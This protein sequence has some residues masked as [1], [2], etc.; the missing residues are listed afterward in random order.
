MFR[1][2]QSPTSAIT[3]LIREIDRYVQDEFKEEKDESDKMSTMTPIQLLEE[4]K[5]ILLTTRNC[6]PVPR[7]ELEMLCL[8]VDVTG[9]KVHPSIKQRGCVLLTSREPILR[10]QLLKEGLKIKGTVLEEYGGRLKI[11]FENEE[12]VKRNLNEENS[13]LEAYIDMTTMDRCSNFK[14]KLSDLYL[15]NSLFKTIVDFAYEKNYS[16]PRS[17]FPDIDKI[18]RSSEFLTSVKDLNEFQQEAVRLSASCKEFHI[19]HGPPGTGKTR[20]LVHLLQL[21]LKQRMKVLVCSHSNMAVDK[22]IIEAEKLGLFKELQ[23]SPLRYGDPAR[24]DEPSVKYNIRKLMSDWFKRGL[25]RDHSTKDQLTKKIFGNAQLV[26]STQ[27]SMMRE[28]F[29]NFYSQESQ[30]FDFVLFDEASQSPFVTSLMP[31]QVTR[32]IILAGDHQQLPPVI[33]IID[34]SA[35]QNYPPDQ[36]YQQSLFQRLVTKQ[37][38]ASSISSR[39]DYCYSTMLRLQFRMNE[40]IALTSNDFFYQGKLLSDKKNQRLC[41]ANYSPARNG[42][43][44]F[45]DQSVPIVWIDCQSQETKIIDRKGFNNKEEANLVVA[46]VDDLMKNLNIQP[47]NIGII[48]SYKEQQQLVTNTLREHYKDLYNSAIR[49]KLE[50]STVDGFQGREKEI[51][52]FSATR[53]NNGDKVGFL[54]DER[55]INV[56]ITRA[57]RLVVMIGNSRTLCTQFKQTFTTNYFKNVEKYGDVLTFNSLSRRLVL[58]NRDKKQKYEYIEHSYSV[59]DNILNP[60][61]YFT[62]DPELAQSR[63]KGVFIPDYIEK[64]F[65]E[66]D[67]DINSDTQGNEQNFNPEKGYWGNLMNNE[68]PSFKKEPKETGIS[69]FDEENTILGNNANQQTS[70]FMNSNNEKDKS[71]NMFSKSFNYEEWRIDRNKTKI[72]ERFS[73]L[74]KEKVDK[75]TECWAL[76]DNPD[77][78]IEDLLNKEGW[79]DEDS[80]QILVEYTCQQNE[81]KLP[82]E[83]EMEEKKAPESSNLFSRGIFSR[84]IG[85]D[86]DNLART[87]SNFL[88]INPLRNEGRSGLF[89]SLTNKQSN[90]TVSKK[91]EDM[92]EKQQTHPKPFSFQAE[93]RQTSDRDGRLFA[94]SFGSSQG[95]ILE[96]WLEDRFPYASDKQKEVLARYQSSLG[97]DRRLPLTD[98]L[99]SGYYQAKEDLMKVLLEL[100]E[101]ENNQEEKKKSIFDMSADTAGRIDESEK[102]KDVSHL[103]LVQKPAIQK[104]EQK[105]TILKEKRETQVVQKEEVNKIVLTPDD[106]L[107]RK[108]K[109][110]EDRIKQLEGE[111]RT[112]KDHEVKESERSPQGRIHS[113]DHIH[114]SRN[115]ID[116]RRTYDHPPLD[117]GQGNSPNQ[118]NHHQPL[119]PGS[120]KDPS[121][122]TS[123]FNKKKST[124]PFSDDYDEDF[125]N[126]F[127]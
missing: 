21:L 101:F 17:S 46:I 89:G 24:I 85:S 61:H 47:N 103:N 57:H 16:I 71:S 86:N 111:L 29:I 83:T 87:G 74:D 72:R 38:L 18:K 58:T 120:P 81:S 53:S 10:S 90:P 36:I 77:A 41:L 9:N 82:K 55:R 1:D 27:I 4:G 109:E 48:T 106:E 63:L 60:L 98:W 28:E 119:S 92:E 30:M 2:S 124:N 33:T 108:L 26:F 88:G 126:P 107:K 45:F 100:W 31:L 65:K 42:K 50:I 15:H 105:N 96:G 73:G 12:A 25:T 122:T 39:S 80:S 34:K 32:R 69:R 104:S 102:S 68:L 8:E 52:I 64:K 6:K 116:D 11:L 127:G 99:S 62:P 91:T 95:P 19:I 3:A 112:Q 117:S 76:Q 78:D 97:I 113:P 20:T 110:A 114:Q 5:A 22:L 79:L 67:F 54:G 66:G 121:P 84:A 44:K 94:K 59:S 75:L 7:P 14:S 40:L 56:A 93:P 51:I 35:S 13:M 37:T 115:Q 49:G 118:T 23:C 123:D 70:I 125:Y 43:S